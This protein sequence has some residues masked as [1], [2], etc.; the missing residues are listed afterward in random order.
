MNHAVLSFHHPFTGSPGWGIAWYI[1]SLIIPEIT[2]MRNKEYTFI[3][4]GGDN[5]DQ[6]ANYHPFYITD[7]EVGGYAQKTP[8]DRQ[9]CGEGGSVGLNIHFWCKYSSDK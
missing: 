5:P 6:T 9:V 7:D 4:N 8:E 3:I 1:N 2:V